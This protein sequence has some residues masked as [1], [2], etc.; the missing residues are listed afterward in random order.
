MKKLPS[1]VMQKRK[2]NAK[3]QKKFQA[4]SQLFGHDHTIFMGINKIMMLLCQNMLLRQNIE[5]FLL[6]CKE[7]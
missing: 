2:K 7:F 4:Y 5:K 6:R 3:Y 1:K